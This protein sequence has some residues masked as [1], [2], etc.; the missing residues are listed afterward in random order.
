M[1]RSDQLSSGYGDIIRLVQDLVS[2]SLLKY[3]PTPREHVEL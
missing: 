2:A 1:K 3:Q